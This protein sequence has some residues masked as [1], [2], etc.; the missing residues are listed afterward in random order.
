MSSS[1]LTVTINNDFTGVN[2]GD[3]NS[4]NVDI[5]VNFQGKIS[6]R[7]VKHFAKTIKDMLRE[8]LDNTILVA[9]KNYSDGFTVHGYATDTMGLD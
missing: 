8:E 3:N 1:D 5:Q 9:A 7:H 6:N 2:D 4:F